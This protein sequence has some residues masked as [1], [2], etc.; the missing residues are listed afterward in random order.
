MDVICIEE[1]HYLQQCPDFVLKEDGELFNRW[2]RS[3][4]NNPR[5]IRWHEVGQKILFVGVNQAKGGGLTF[6][7][8]YLNII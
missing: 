4:F 2:S 7:Q 5:H 6:L 1:L 8:R 3:L